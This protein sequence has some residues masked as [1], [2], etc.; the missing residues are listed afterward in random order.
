MP[1]R[2]MPGKLGKCCVLMYSRSTLSKKPQLLKLSCFHRMLFVTH[3]KSIFRF[4]NLI[5]PLSPGDSNEMSLHNAA[6]RAGLTLDCKITYLEIPIC[7][8]YD[9]DGVPTVEMKGWPF[10]LPS[11]MDAWVY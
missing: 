2:L 8:G 6:R 11:D 5:E 7:T 3:H 10:L 1:L 9:D 4:C